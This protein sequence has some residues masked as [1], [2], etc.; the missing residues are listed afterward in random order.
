MIDQQALTEALAMTRGR[1][2]GNG[3]TGIID[4]GSNSV[5]LVLYERASRAPL[6]FFNEKVLAGL[7]EGL[8]A[9]GALSEDAMERAIDA[10]RRFVMIA[11]HAEARNLTVIATAAV[12]EASNGAAFIGT[13]EARTGERVRVLA[14]RE[15]AQMAANGVLCGFW[16]PDGVVGD[17]GGGSLELIDV[18]GG[19]LGPGDSFALGTLRI[20]T[21]AK[22]SLAQAAKIAASQLERAPQ[23]PLLSGRTFYAVG[24]TWR[25]LARLHM[26]S[27]RYPLSVYHHYT[28]D[29]DEMMDL[30]DAILK[31]GVDK[32]SGNSAVSKAR[33]ALLP[34]GAVVMREIMRRGRPDHVAASALGV[35]EGL[36]YAELANDQK[37][38]DPLLIAAEELALLRA[39]SPRHS[40]ELVG[41]TAEVFAALGI[42]E[43]EEEARLR[44]ASCLLSDI[45]WRAHPD[46]RGDQAIAMVSNA[47]IYGID[48]PGRGFI[49]LALSER[50]GG[51]NGDALPAARMI[52]PARLEFKAKLLGTAFRVA[53]VLAP[54]LPD[55]L[56]RLRLRNERGFLVLS[57]PR[58]LAALDGERPRRRLKQLAK[59]A[60][61][62]SDVRIVERQA[63]IA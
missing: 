58:D 24:G 38:R 17:L 16:K 3:V 9:G 29:R 44:T 6:V 41:W 30:C 13:I 23:L 35:R 22:G 47:S 15:E 56:P 36:I 18:A 32:L 63:M 5:R 34:W 51:I 33:R 20:K 10:I 8:E 52:C 61:A 53:Y 21:D 1:R 43:T 11:E 60:N 19:D 57:I 46:Y 48:H 62:E 14:G 55:I 49:A 45:G 28:I 2:M 27:K 31:D 37:V 59:M 26:A 40:G 54:G 7:G 4:I 39:R 50:Y 25:A 12:R 42:S